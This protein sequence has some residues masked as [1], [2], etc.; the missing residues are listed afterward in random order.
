MLVMDSA[1]LIH[2][3]RERAALS[4]EQL[5]A[6]AQTSQAAIARYERGRIAPNVKVLTRLLAACGL[7][8]QVELVPLHAD[9]DSEIHACLDR[10]PAERLV[11]NGWNE[12]LDN[13]AERR[14]RYVLGGQIAALLYG[15][16]VQQPSGTVALPPDLDV[17]ERFVDGAKGFVSELVLDEDSW[18]GLYSIRP[19]AIAEY[20]VEHRHATFRGWYGHLLASVTDRVEDFDTVVATAT[21][22]TVGV[23]DVAV[24]PVEDALD[25]VGHARLVERFRDMR[26]G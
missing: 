3:A 18:Q 23:I 9:V 26:K 22:V 11:D 6:A 8:A 4:Q 25:A 5:A 19:R 16:P 21:T 1:K 20:L 7:E 14:V 10:T 2:D 12:L 15:V 24:V 17:L 13:L